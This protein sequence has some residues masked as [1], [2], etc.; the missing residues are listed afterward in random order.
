M[1]LVCAYVCMHVCPKSE[2]TQESAIYSHSK[3]AKN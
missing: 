2:N 1:Q 3:N